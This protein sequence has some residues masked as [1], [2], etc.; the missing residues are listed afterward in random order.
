ML[1][2]GIAREIIIIPFFFFSSQ[3]LHK[4]GFIFWLFWFIFMLPRMG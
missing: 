2:K 1:W 4:I 3:L